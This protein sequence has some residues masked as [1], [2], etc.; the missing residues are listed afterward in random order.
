MSL[1]LLILMLLTM[2]AVEYGWFFLKQQQ[3]TNAAR[4]AARVAS[5]AEATNATVDAQITTLMNS[6]GMGS[7]GYS[8]TF[9]WGNTTE[10][11]TISR[12]TSVSVNISVPYSKITITNFK[13]LPMP[14]NLQ[15][16]VAMAKEGS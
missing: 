11:S 7:T 9:S 10:I 2:G 3:I 15:S 6:Y 5:T 16:T 8:K 12:G 1:A 13:L 4:Q 14:A